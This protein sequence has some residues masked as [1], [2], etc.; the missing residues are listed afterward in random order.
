MVLQTHVGKSSGSSVMFIP[1]IGE[2]QAPDRDDKAI[3]PYFWD[4]NRYMWDNVISHGS[5]WVPRV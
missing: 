1:R 3:R 4:T 2:E 5:G